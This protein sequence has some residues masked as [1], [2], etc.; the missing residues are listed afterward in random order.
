M[1]PSDRAAELRFQES[2]FEG[3]RP[4]PRAPEA[5]PGAAHVCIRSAAVGASPWT[6]GLGA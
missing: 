4:R 3:A 1:V 6:A 5:G 2:R